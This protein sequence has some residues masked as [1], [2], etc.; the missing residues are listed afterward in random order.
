[1]IELITALF[2]NVCVI[3]VFAYIL[4]RTRFF[5]EILEQRF[6]RQNRLILILVCGLFSIYG[7]IG[8][9]EILGGI[10]NIRDLGPAI[11][12]LLAGPVVGVAAGLIGGFH[13]LFVG[14]FTA[15]PCT[16]A[17]IIAGFLGGIVFLLRKKKIPSVYAA[18]G[19]AAGMEILHMGLVLLLSRPYDEAVSIVRAIT[20][21]MIVANA[22]GLGIFFFIVTNL[23]SE[24]K[25]RS[26]KNMI[27]GELRGAR[28]I[29]MSIVPRIYP[30]FPDLD[31]IDLCAKL[32]PAKEV[33]G[34]LY[35]Y[36][37]LDE[38][39]NELFFMVG[40]VSDKGVPASLFMIITMTLFKANVAAGAELT[41][42]VERVNNQLAEDNT[43]NM[44]VTLF[45]GIMNIASG[46][47]R[48]VNAGHN[49]PLVIRRDRQPEF[50]ASTGDLVMGA[51]PGID[52][53]SN[54]MMLHPG[55]TLLIYTDGITEAFNPAQQLF[56]EQR[57][58]EAARGIN[59]LSASQGVDSIHD[60]VTRFAAGAT[61][62]D[63]LTL[64]LVRYKP[65][66]E[67]E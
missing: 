63:D 10:A 24:L 4:T 43:S 11:A 6:T 66:P 23:I 34:D 48:Y 40:D 54:T 38:S 52:Y 8:G 65:E 47:I 1:M 46:E 67:P 18:A 59:S 56:S 22:L 2:P 5:N 12:G 32:V 29:Q 49:P 42:I 37:L 27:E 13:R 3:M 16:G 28:E 7:T 26:E 60:A 44:F 62:S 35:D 58:I 30:A 39:K 53:H 25:T 61:Q 45:C 51:M 41:K 19:F 50:I 31:K 17:T 33:G 64:L 36:Y 57:L 14:G 15:V 21:P 20:I 9:M 55:D